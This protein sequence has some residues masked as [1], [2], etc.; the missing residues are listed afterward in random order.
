MQCVKSL[1]HRTSKASW[2]SRLLMVT[3]HG[4]ARFQSFL[5]AIE[6]SSLPWIQLRNNPLTLY[7]GW[8]QGSVPESA[9]KD[10]H[11][12]LEA[13]DRLFRAGASPGVHLGKTFVAPHAGSE[14]LGLTSP[15]HACFLPIYALNRAHGAS[16]RHFEVLRVTFG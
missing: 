3:L 15:S 6:R 8:L 16:C 7:G 10:I 9:K 12:L 14:T 2:P 11:R 1:H 5:T 13:L 4:P